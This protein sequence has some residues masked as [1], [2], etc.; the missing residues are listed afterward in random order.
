MPILRTRDRSAESQYNNF[1]LRPVSVLDAWPSTPSYISVT[2]TATT[3]TASVGWPSA[4]LPGDFAL[5]VYE[6]SGDVTPNPPS[7]WIQIGSPVVDV[8]DAT[9]S[10]LTVFYRLA[11]ADLPATS[12]PAD[13]D[14]KV[15]SI[16]VFRGV[17][18]TPFTFATATKTTP[19]TSL[20]FPD[21]TLP[22]FNNRVVFIA[23]RPDDTA[24]ASFSNLTNSNL[25][26][27]AERR[28]FGTA[29][30]NG[31]GHCIYTGL[32]SNPGPIGTSD[33]T[34]A[35]SVT[36]ACMVLALEPSLA[37]PA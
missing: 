7:D 14:H 28:D 9:G 5:L 13:T 26:S 18:L 24:S 37:Y 16:A 30:G 21:L 8:A 35:N 27:I 12:F 20:T 32:A 6:T 1:K 15:A 36:N 4:A 29:N 22:S 34:M 17:S 31:G 33:I 2:G 25:T 3:G 23:T 11:P 10:T 19:S